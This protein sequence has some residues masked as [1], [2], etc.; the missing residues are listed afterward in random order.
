[1]SN[2]RD[3]LREY[4]N[5]KTVIKDE[6]FKQF[7]NNISCSIC[8]DI[9]IEPV[10]CMKCQAQC[11]KACQEDWLKKGNKGCTNRCTNTTFNKSILAQGLLS[12]LKFICGKCEQVFNYDD[13][14]KH[15]LINCK[16]DSKIKI[17]IESSI[18]NDNMESIKSMYI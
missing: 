9:M 12:K 16:N 5:D 4:I 15:S 6:I 17:L 18:K 10:M 11:C 14:E 7:E 8:L 3:N 2:L 1:M 13:M